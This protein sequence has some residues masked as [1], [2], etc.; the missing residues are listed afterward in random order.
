MNKYEAEY[1]KQYVSSS[2]GLITAKQKI[3]TVINSTWLYSMHWKDDTWIEQAK[4]DVQKRIIEVTKDL[5]LLN[6]AELLLN[7]IE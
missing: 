5:A 2:D 3:A 7:E 4:S 1:K 6:Q